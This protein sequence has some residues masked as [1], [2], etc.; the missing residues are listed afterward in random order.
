MT[1]PITLITLTPLSTNVMIQYPV[2][3]AAAAHGEHHLRL[4]CRT[5]FGCLSTA[6]DV[7]MSEWVVVL[8][9]M[10]RRTIIR[11]KTARVKSGK[12]GA[13]QVWSIDATHVLL[14]D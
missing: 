8:S 11:K 7:N 12:Q 1:G 14:S 10:R 2:W 6:D 4:P 9:V 3:E 13:A 5:G